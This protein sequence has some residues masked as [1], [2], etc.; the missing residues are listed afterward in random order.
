M[1]QE[2]LGVGRAAA[3]TLKKRPGYGRETCPV[4]ALFHFIPPSG[5]YLGIAPESKQ[6]PLAPSSVVLYK[7]LCMAERASGLECTLSS[8]TWEAEARRGPQRPTEYFCEF[9]AT[10]VYRSKFQDSQGNRVSGSTRDWAGM[11]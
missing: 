5:S 10:L 6:K 2:K 7:W 3:K 11:G 8:S 4:L 9:K 1:H